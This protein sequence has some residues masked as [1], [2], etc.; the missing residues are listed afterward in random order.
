VS[1]PYQD[2]PP[3]LA[4]RERL[5]FPES[6]APLEPTPEFR[7][8]L[9]TLGVQLEGDEPRRLGLYLALL[10]FANESMNLTAIKDPGEAWIKHIADS[11]SLIPVLTELSDGASIVDIGSGGGVP[12]LPLAIVLPQMRFTLLESTGKKV[13]FLGAAIKRLGLGNARVVQARA[14][15]A[16]RKRPESRAAVNPDV[17]GLRESF[18]GAIARAV[19][20]LNVLV[21]LAIPLIKVGGRAILV[22]GQ[23]AD[24]ELAQAKGALRALHAEHIGTIETPTGR[25]VVLEKT[26]PTNRLYPRPDGEPAK[27]PL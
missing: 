7:K 23:R 14:E 3:R 21:E 5:V 1:K 18:D 26:A 6:I 20:R 12:G 24:E 15:S 27:H 25:L 17:P 22:K 4:T 16:G 11:L 8:A 19:G 13:E 2:R 9:E 10:L